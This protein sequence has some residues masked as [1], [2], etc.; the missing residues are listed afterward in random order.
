MQMLRRLNVRTRLVAVI[1]VPL[2]LLLAVVVPEAIQRRDL[3]EDADRAAQAT[4]GVADVAAA[5]DA[6]QGERTLSAALRSGAGPDV[7]RA[8]A[9]QRAITDDAVERAGR[10]L[11]ALAA[12]DPALVT[13]TAAAADRV[14]ELGTLREQAD[15]AV[16]DVPWIDPYV[17]MLDALLQVQESVGAV[18]TALGMDDR[19]SA[20]ALVARSK[21]A[22]AA[23]DAQMA[24]ASS[25]GEVRGEQRT[26]LRDQRTDEAAFRAAYLAAS[27]P[28]GLAER[29][30]EVLA[31]AVTET[32]R[33]V[34]G[35]AAG[36]VPGPLTDWLDQSAARQQVLREVEAERAADALSAI[37]DVE[38]SA[39]DSSTG[40][41]VLAGTGLLL[42]LGL[43]LAA[44]RSITR[45]LRE[46]TD[47]ADI[48]A[49]E[50]LPQLVD[51]LRRP[52]ED[53]ER[54]LPATIE[55]LAVHADDE[56]G[57]LAHA[58]N[59]V[60]SVA[61]DVAAEQALL[62]KKGISDLYVNL[63]RR[64]QAL[65]DRQIQLL[66]QL[67]AEE[68][69]TE[70][71]QHLYL[72]DHLAT[73]M[74]RN[75]ESLLIL[76]GSESGP[77]RSKPIEVVDVVRAA[78]SEVEDY[79]R[80]EL[81]SLASA[82]LHGPAGSDVA[83]LVAELLENA[84][85][86]SPPDTHVRVDG[87][88]T[89]GSYQLVI[90]DKGVG[91]RP[92][93]LVELNQVL[94]DPPVTGLALGR[95]L[96]CL[97]AARLAARHGITVR[98]R[99]GEDEGVVAYVILPQ[100]LL[101]EEQ[102]E[103]RPAPLPTSAGEP[104]AGDGWPLDWEAAEGPEPAAAVP[105]A[106]APRLVERPPAPVRLSDALPARSEFDAGI[107]ALLD[108]EG[109]PTLVEPP[110]PTRTAAV[111]AAAEDTAAS[112]RRRVPGATAEALPEPIV[113]PPVRRDP[114]EVRALLSRYRSGLEAGRVSDSSADEERS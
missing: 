109:E 43:A 91:M 110:L 9:V 31:G 48:L 69:D 27:P 41:L 59:A 80:I 79:E 35:V 21:D 89:A 66:D 78:L 84:T 103:P 52:V 71:L 57:Q 83:H 17:P 18:T 42:A 102:G 46:L 16:S 50:R 56:L 29:R 68:Q 1:A 34:D 96:G 106:V 55:P 24:A 101:V 25:W 77:R 95:A 8:L 36:A 76:A 107:Q 67:E 39:R 3:A 92:E 40:Y 72:L 70:V 64:N 13:P 113:D 28:G 38:A 30:S 6:L 33:V 58:F 2:V 63:A 74:R 61:V 23:Q 93:Q 14:A 85:Q 81:G 54:H 75:A 20:V 44:A 60:Q 26:T 112:L 4:T 47:A 7:E 5:T 97:V 90:T 10:A 22:A 87:T 45:P 86:F 53:D 114:D 62:L 94:L 49:S 15:T 73:R 88:A 19:L 99:T 98:L 32:G 11:A 65:I 105:E 82:T 12:L 51:A 104:A 111:A 37:E 100:H 108:R